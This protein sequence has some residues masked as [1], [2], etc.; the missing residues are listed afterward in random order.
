M[1]KSQ[2]GLP[3]Y[4]FIFNLTIALNY[5]PGKKVERDC[6]L[7]WW[8]E[9][10][11]GTKKIPQAF[12]VF[13]SE[14]VTTEQGIWDP[15]TGERYV[16]DNW[17]N[18]LD[19]KWEVDWSGFGE[20]PM[21]ADA[22]T[23]QVLDQ[24]LTDEEKKRLSEDE[25]RKAITPGR[26]ASATEPWATKEAPR[27]DATIPVILRDEG[28]VPRGRTLQIYVLLIT[29][30]SCANRFFAVTLRGDGTSSVGDQPPSSKKPPTKATGPWRP[31]KPM[32]SGK[33]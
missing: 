28:F 6:V 25:Q 11:G 2:G 19:P 21:E 33:R 29:S 22:A 3:G 31:A 17:N 32:P 20:T 30:C 13:G 12:A 24:L 26:M 5:K 18:I 27:C 10:S 23:R 4:H 9:F 16:P 1:A 8:E 14:V 7:E 15:A